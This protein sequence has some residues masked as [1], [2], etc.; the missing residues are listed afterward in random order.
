MSPRYALY[1]TPPPGSELAGLG[2]A[3]L[4]YDCHSGEFVAQPP[5][6]G[7]DP[8]ELRTHTAEPR[9]Y[10]FH[11]TLKAPFSLKEGASLDDLKNA[12]RDFASDHRAFAAGTL[13]PRPLGRFI[14]LTLDM[15]SVE[16][17][18]FAA[19]CVAALDGFRA[20]LSER[21]LQRREAANLSARQRNLLMRWG[22]PYVFDQF[23][24]HMTLTGPLPQERVGAWLES[25]EH[26]MGEE[27]TLLMDSITL[28]EQAG[29]D[30]PFRVVSRIGLGG[31]E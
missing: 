23:R 17:S 2:A 11:G 30:E 22:Y 25:L 1:F 6:R 24:F 12:V 9:R 28:L 7:I 14:A 16:L 21:D 4:G 3:V 8:E 29:P 26:R 13:S 19:E 15:P 31:Q 18:L 27:R 20:P 10:G 5:L